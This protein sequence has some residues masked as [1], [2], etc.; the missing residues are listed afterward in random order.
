MQSQNCEVRCHLRG[1]EIAV[2]PASH[3]HAFLTVIRLKKL[4]GGMKKAV[5]K[6]ET[7]ESSSNFSCFI[8]KFSWFIRAFVDEVINV[9][10]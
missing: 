4:I 8:N 5:P 7:V 10:V 2:Q 1:Q 6:A 3:G 9:V